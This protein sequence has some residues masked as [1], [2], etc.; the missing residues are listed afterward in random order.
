MTKHAAAPAKADRPK[1]KKK[2]NTSAIA[3]VILLAV[4]LAGVGIMAYPTVSDWWNSFHQTRAIIAYTAEVETLDTSYMDEMLAEAEAYNGRLVRREDRFQLSDEELEEYEGLLD[5][6]GNG[7]MGYIEINAINVHLPIGHGT[8]ERVLQNAVGHIEGTSLPVGGPG[9]HTVLSGH[10]GLPSAKL[11]TELDKLV[12][13]DL[14]TVTVL[15]RTLTYMVDQ[16]RIVEPSDMSD[17]AIE[18]GKDYCTLVTCTPY[19]INT[20]RLLV[21][22]HR[23][24]NAEEEI[25]VAGEAVRVPYHTVILAVSVPLMFLFL[26]VMLILYSFKRTTR[27]QEELLRQLRDTEAAQSQETEKPA[28]EDSGPSEDPAE[29]QD[30]TEQ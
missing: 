13:G 16:I 15:N 12:E 27:P 9:T 8:S 18:A 20:H 4:L 6:T 3:T 29:P 28:Q 22:G 1:P 10:R 21:R 24:E 2:R 7:L 19:A 17:L 25:T 5:P 30:H 26:F 14:F 23:V 11:F